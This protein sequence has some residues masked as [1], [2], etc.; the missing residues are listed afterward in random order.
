[1]VSKE[2][3]LRKEIISNLKH[4]YSQMINIDRDSLLSA[5]IS[6]LQEIQKACEV[7]TK[8]NQAA[9]AIQ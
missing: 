6:E 1:M 9:L 5:S 8:M 7:A 2:I 4:N 3:T